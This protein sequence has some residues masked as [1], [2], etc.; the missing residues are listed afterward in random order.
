MSEG[1]NAADLFAIPDFWK[2]SSWNQQPPPLA[3]KDRQS[4]FFS[5]DINGKNR[6]CVYFLHRI[7]IGAQAKNRSRSSSARTKRSSHHE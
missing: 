1:D 6:V 3:P 4:G 2:L 5:L 7:L